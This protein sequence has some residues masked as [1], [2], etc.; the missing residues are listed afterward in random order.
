VLILHF[1]DLHFYGEDQWTREVFDTQTKMLEAARAFDEVESAGLA[2]HIPYYDYGTSNVVSYK[3]RSARVN[4]LSFG[5]G[6]ME[7]LKVDLVQGR[8]FGRGDDALERQPVVINRHLRDELFGGEDPIG[9]KIK[10][11]IWDREY[12]VVGVMSDFR[13]RGEFRET[14]RVMLIRGTYSYA[15]K[16]KDVSGWW[17]HRQLMIRLRPGTTIRQEERM[18]KKIQDIARNWSFEVTTM[19]ERRSKWLKDD[20]VSHIGLGIIGMLVMLMVCLGLMGVLWQNVACRTRE[21]GLRRAKGATIAHIFQQIMG[22]LLMITT[23]GLF[24]GLIVVVQFPLLDVLG[25]VSGS[26]FFIGITGA[27]MIMYALTVL[28]SLYPSFMATRIHPAEALHYE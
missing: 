17:P 14:E 25:S 16:A 5:D 24:L 20:M 22:E 27:M 23:I 19:E 28:C 7:V 1:H 26:S 3:D 15:D 18:I 12:L 11:T 9:K 2:F 13:K 10:D 21:I 8:Y 6:T 4:R